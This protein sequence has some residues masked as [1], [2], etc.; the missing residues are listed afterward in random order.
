MGLCCF[1]QSEARPSPLEGMMRP[2]TK[3]LLKA[4]WGLVASVLSLTCFCV[5]FYGLAKGR[6]EMWQDFSIMGL[7]FRVAGGENRGV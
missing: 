5:S 1:S 7:L 4:A 6:N 3:E 2:E